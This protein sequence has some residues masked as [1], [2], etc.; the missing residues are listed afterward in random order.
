MEDF[1]PDSLVTIEGLYWVYDM[2]KFSRNG[3]RDIKV[4]LKTQLENS[5]N[6]LGVNDH[7]L[8]SWQKKVQRTKIFRINQG[9][10]DSLATP[11]RGQV[12]G[13]RTC[14]EADEKHILFL[15]CQRWSEIFFVFPNK[16]GGTPHAAR[17][18][19]QMCLLRWEEFAIS[20]LNRTVSLVNKGVVKL[21]YWKVA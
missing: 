1:E 10:V 18:F 17:S 16:D 19:S 11:C 21:P 13:H 20:L 5:S 7:D 3:W 9:Y 15:Y 14:L 12:L 4:G 2:I 8:K 6:R